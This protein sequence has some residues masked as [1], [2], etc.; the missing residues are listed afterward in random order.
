MPDPTQPPV[1]SGGDFL[2][3]FVA[4]DAGTYWYQPHQRTW[5]QMAR[6]LCGALIVEEP[7]PPPVDR[8]GI[9]LIDDWRPT[10]DAFD[11]VQVVVDEVEV[12]LARPDVDLVEIL[13]PHLR[14]ALS[15]SG[16]A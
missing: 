12:R 2:Y 10:E 5:E 4:P 9:L 16:A 7:T 3:D 14:T 13:L 11:K 8:E 15:P 1:P 6:G